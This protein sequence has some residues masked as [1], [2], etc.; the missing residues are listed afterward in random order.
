VPG[1]SERH[2]YV[3]SVVYSCGT[4]LRNDRL[5]IAYGTSDTSTTFA[6]VQLD[7]LL[8]ELA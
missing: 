5:V 7:A 4:L 1:E 6:T 2:G 8:A 3:P